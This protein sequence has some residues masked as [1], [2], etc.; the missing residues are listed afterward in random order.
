MDLNKIHFHINDAQWQTFPEPKWGSLRWKELLNLDRGNSKEFVFGFAELPS[1]GRLPF[2]THRQA[3]TDHIMSG[4][5]RVRLG[6]RSVE[7]GP[8]SALYFPAGLPHSIETLGSEAVLFI[9]TYACEKA[10]HPPDS[11]LVQE[12]EAAQVN[13][14]N[15][16][17]ITWATRREST[18]WAIREEIETWIPLEL[19]KGLKA[20]YRCF[21]GHEPGIPREMMAGIAE[22][23]P[24][25]H[26][27]LHDHEQP[28]I[29]YVLSGRGIIY[30]EDSGIEVSPGSSL[31][32]G[33]RIA[34][35]ADCTG[36]DS[37][38]LY[39]IY[40]LETAGKED[41]WTPLE[42]IYTEV[43]RQK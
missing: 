33:R 17:N 8:F 34:H 19:S 42:D 39:F 7:V 18:R 14:L 16:E 4:E 13:I 36:E 9:Y 11:K 43:R 29:Y 37:L 35:G 28:E 24:G 21:F 22:I 15:K 32:V 26:Y 12:S 10:G 40:G 20:R 1:G 2:H 41:T 30:V 6:S 3:E 27:T 23:A 5:A 38:R 31:Y 25:I